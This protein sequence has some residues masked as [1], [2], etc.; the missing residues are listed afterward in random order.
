MTA[1]APSL[2][3]AAP[4]R[5]KVVLSGTERPVK[6]TINVK[7]STDEVKRLGDTGPNGERT[8]TGFECASGTQ[9]QALPKGPSYDS[10][11]DEWSDCQGDP[12]RLDIQ[13]VL[14]FA[15]MGSVDF[16]G[17]AMSS[18]L[19]ALFAEAKSAAQQGDNAKAAVAGNEI[20]FLLFE[21]GDPGLAAEFRTVTIRSAGEVLFAKSDAKDI[22]LFV[23][24][25]LQKRDVTS[26]EARDVLEKFQASEGLKTTGKWD[27]PTLNALAKE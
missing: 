11:P 9:I 6:S 4:L 7:L 8:F 2:A 27:L 21:A 24:D 15:A 25:P 19:Q 16:T 18:D 22:A 1:A 13:P 3:L 5:V 12:V 26:P 17:H 14:S 23:Y 20:T 10:R